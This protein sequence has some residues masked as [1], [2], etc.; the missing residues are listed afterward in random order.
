MDSRNGSKVCICIV[1][2][3]EYDNVSSRFPWSEQRTRKPRQPISETTVNPRGFRWNRRDQLNFALE[4]GTANQE[5]PVKCIHRA[6]KGPRKANLHLSY[7]KYLG[8]RFTESDSLGF[9]IAVG[10]MQAFNPSDQL[11]RANRTN[12]PAD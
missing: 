7:E 10:D 5:C 4:L 9:T 3:Q 12:G 2:D 1:G 11:S 8:V 6:S